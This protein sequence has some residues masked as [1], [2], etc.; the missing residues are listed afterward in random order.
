MNPVLEALATQNW[1]ATGRLDLSGQRLR[2]L[3]DVFTAE[4]AIRRL[5][6]SGNRLT[7]LPPSLFRLGELT[8]LDLG[9]NRLRAL[10]PEIGAFDRLIALDASENRL[11][12]LPPEL[13]ACAALR[14]VQ[15]YGNMLS[16]LAPLAELP[17]L[18]TLD[19]SGN[20]LR[21]LAGLAPGLR[22]LDLS[23][24][25]L[26]EL[27]GTVRE[28]T[29]LTNLDLSGNRLTNVDALL[30][31]PLTELHLDDNAL[32]EWPSVVATLSTLRLYSVLGNPVQDPNFVATQVREAVH[33][34][35]TG[36]SDPTKQYFDVA[37]L[38][39]AFSL[40]VSGVGAI[41]VLVD[42]YYKRFRHINAAITLADGTRIELAGLSRTSAH[43]MLRD[44]QETATSRALMDF[45]PTKSLQERRWTEEY[46]VQTAARLPQVDLVPTN[47][48]VVHINNYN[49]QP[50]IDMGDTI[51][52]VGNTNSNI[53]VKATLTKVTQNIGAA[54]TLDNNT[55]AELDRLLGQLQGALAGLPAEQAEDAEAVAD[56]TADLVDKA[57]KDK[58]NRKLV[59]V[60]A[61]G[62]RT[63]VD[64]LAT[65]SPIALNIISLV[66]KIIGG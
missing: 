46:L 36:H 52:V 37:T 50:R 51:N 12:A 20:R 1:A 32:T 59:T 5:D 3:P 42:Q 6:L 44:A 25:Q 19:V 15:L 53:N 17:G 40:A 49:Y 39:F 45:P 55:K 24:N 41:R 56:A 11:T 9:N 58:P 43:R 35:T 14:D 66:N 54:A 26:T 27:P 28:L 48:T 2:E 22:T 29:R 38:T 16:D 62:L 8:E 60:A 18:T 23:G 4:M 47:G 7:E 33:A 63:L 61:S 57:T 65:I 30:D 10:P 64:G 31:L 21:T 13:A 34:H